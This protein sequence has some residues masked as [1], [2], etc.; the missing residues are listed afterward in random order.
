MN[1]QLVVRDDTHFMCSKADFKHWA[2]GGKKLRMEFFY[3]KMRQKYDVL[4]QGSEPEG[5]CIG[6]I[7]RNWVK[8]IITSIIAN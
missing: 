3:R 2:A 6:L 1:T 5:G 8:V 7:C 4:M